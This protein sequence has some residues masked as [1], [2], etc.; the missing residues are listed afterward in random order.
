GCILQLDLLDLAELQLYRRGATE[1]Q[2]R[3]LNATLLVVDLFDHT[4]EIGERTVCNSN[5]LTRLEQRLRLRLVAAVSNA[6]QDSLGFLIGDWRRLIRRATDEAHHTRR[7]LD[8]V[9]RTFGHIHLNQDVT[10]KELALTLALLPVTH[11][12]DFFSGDQNLA[13]M[14]FHT[15]KLDALDQ[16]T[17][18]ML[19]VTRVSMNHVPTLSHGTPLTNNHGNQP[20]EQ[21]IKPPQQQRHNQHNGQND[22]RGLSGFLTGRPN[23]FS[24]LDAR[25][26]Q[27]RERCTTLC[28]LQRNQG[29]HDSNDEQGYHP[30]Q[31]RLGGVVLI[32]DDSHYHQS[33]DNKPLHQVEACVLGFC[34][35]IH[36]GEP[37]KKLPNSLLKV[38]GQEGIEPPTC[39][40]GD[41]RSA[42]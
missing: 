38:A 27:Q 23:D 7:I 37:C 14:I 39:G 40:F 3:D 30:I 20:T 28:R 33:S 34:F 13:E 26:F 11:L 16:R 24:N 31:N 32:T 1:D 12:H 42:N 25:L 21:G 4:I 35:D 22:Q 10:G 36:L 2:N 15:G 19:L 5:D 8:Q 41:R 9:P 29:S 17:H 18:D 6:T